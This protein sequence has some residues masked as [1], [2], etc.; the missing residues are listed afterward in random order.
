MPPYSRP[1]DRTAPRLARHRPSAAER[2]ARLDAIADKAARLGR[3]LELI[4]KRA[5]ARVARDLAAAARE[6]RQ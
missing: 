3:H 1:P 5:E 4:G 2:A 6:A